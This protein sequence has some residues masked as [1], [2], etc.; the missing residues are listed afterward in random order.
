MID[1]VLSYVQ[2]VLSGEKEGDAAIGRYLMDTLGAATD[3][4]EKSGFNSRLQVRDRHFP[5]LCIYIRRLI[6]VVLAR[7]PSR[8]HTSPTSFALKPKCLHVLH[9][10]LLPRAPFVLLPSSHIENCN[11]DLSHLLHLEHQLLKM[12]E[13]CRSCLVA[14]SS[15]NGQVVAGPSSTSSNGV[16]EFS[17]SKSPVRRL[18]HWETSSATSGRTAC[19]RVC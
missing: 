5:F 9:W 11:N 3:D 14:R 15:P 12:R 10:P 7:I 16:S 1:R 6:G 4:L 8:S 19:R 17:G 18:V 13:C 2:A